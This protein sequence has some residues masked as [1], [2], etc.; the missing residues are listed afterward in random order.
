[1]ILVSTHAKL[2]A[3]DAI[4]YRVDWPEFVVSGVAIPASHEH[5]ASR[6]QAADVSNN[7]YPGHYGRVSSVA[8]TDFDPW[9]D[10]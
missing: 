7:R 3:K 6:K 2:S 8:A 5:F 9:T 4:I 1:M 10:M